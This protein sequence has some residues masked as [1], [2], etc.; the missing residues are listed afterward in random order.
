MTTSSESETY[1]SN[2]WDIEKNQMR[3]PKVYNREKNMWIPYQQIMKSCEKCVAGLS[4]KCI[5]CDK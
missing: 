1:Y 3:T 5:K 2:F 4:G